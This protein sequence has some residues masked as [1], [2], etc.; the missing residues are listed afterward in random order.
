M[1]KLLYAG[2]SDNPKIGAMDHAEIVADSVPKALP[3]FGHCMPE[4]RDDLPAEFVEN[5]EIAVA[6]DVFVHQAPQPFDGCVS[7]CK[8]DPLRGVIGVQN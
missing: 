1:D 6:G 4:E 2:S 8:I 5:L 7:A 3:L